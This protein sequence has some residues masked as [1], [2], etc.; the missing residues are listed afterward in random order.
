MFTKIHQYQA[1]CVK[2]NNFTKFTPM[3]QMASKAS[4]TV[5]KC[6][7]A[8]PLPSVANPTTAGILN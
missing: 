2:K 3:L 6:M 8:L 7:D 4:F 5:V 1:A